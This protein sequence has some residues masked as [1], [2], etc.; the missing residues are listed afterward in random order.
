MATPA[1]RGTALTPSKPDAAAVELL[2][3]DEQLAAAA[4]PSGMLVHRGWARD[5]VV[6]MTAVRDRIGQHVFPVHRLDRGTS[7]VVLFAL[8]SSTAAALQVQFRAGT[9]EKR[10][11]TLTRGITSQTHPPTLSRGPR[12]S[13]LPRS[14]GRIYQ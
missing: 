13:P 6:L 3:R 11:L 7:G 8:D 2:H 1:T 10:Y 12:A 14:G 5:E 4:K 9:V